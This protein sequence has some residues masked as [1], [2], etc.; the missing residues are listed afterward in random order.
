MLQKIIQL[1]CLQ[2]LE[3][4]GMIS[5]MYDTYQPH[6]GLLDPHGGFDPSNV[7]TL[8]ASE[9]LSSRSG[10]LSEAGG[11][12]SSATLPSQVQI[13]TMLA[14]ARFIAVSWQSTETS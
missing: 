5:G 13:L 4:E 10:M 2:S 11:R 9:H 8:T 7:V 14:E 1:S 3:V 6:G 12:C